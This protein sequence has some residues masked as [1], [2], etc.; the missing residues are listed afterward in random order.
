LEINLSDYTVFPNA[1]ITEAV[2]DIKAQLPEKQEQRF[3]KADFKLSQ[4]DK[5]SSFPTKTGTQGYLRGF[6]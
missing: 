2:I 4:K 1:P 6:N 3:L 5:P